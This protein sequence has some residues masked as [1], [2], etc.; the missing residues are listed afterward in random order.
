MAFSALR[1]WWDRVEERRVIRGMKIVEG[2]ETGR[3]GLAGGRHVEMAGQGPESWGQQGR[4]RGRRRLRSPG[5]WHREVDK[6]H[7]KGQCVCVLKNLLFM[8]KNS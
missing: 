5:S 7:S 6:P 4:H 1:S 3:G 2:E 8:T